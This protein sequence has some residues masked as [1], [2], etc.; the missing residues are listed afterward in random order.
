MYNCT[1]RATFLLLYPLARV[2]KRSSGLV[3]LGVSHAS[4]FGRK[5]SVIGLF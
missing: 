1:Y 4:E 3:S 5:A 2:T